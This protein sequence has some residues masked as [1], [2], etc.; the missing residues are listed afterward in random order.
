MNGATRLLLAASVVVPA[1]LFAFLGWQSR[2]D[3]EAQAYNHVRQTTAI[4]HEHALRVFDI[5]ATAIERVIDYR[6][7]HATGAA[8][9][10]AAFHRH[11][12]RIKANQHTILSLWVFAADGSVVASS[13]PRP[14][15]R[16]PFVFDRDYFQHHLQTADRALFFSRPLVGRADRQAQFALTRRLEDAAG[17]FAGVASSGIFSSYFVENWKGIAPELGSSTSLV[18]HDGVVLARN[19]PIAVDTQPLPADSELMLGIRERT[20]GILQARS[21]VDAQERIVGFLKLGGYPAFITYSV[22]LPAVL[23][24]WRRTLLLYA[25]LCGAAAAALAAMTLLVHRRMESEGVALERTRTESEARKIAQEELGRANADLQRLL[26]QLRATDATRTRFFANVSHELRTPLTLILGPVERLLQ[27]PDLDASVREQLDVITRSARVLQ[28]H[29]SDLLDIAK[30]EAGQM[31]AHYVRTDL[32]ALAREVA[33]EFQNAAED[34]RIRLEVNTPA[35]LHAQLDREK[36][37]RMLVNLL[38]NALKFTPDGG[39]IRLGLRERDGRAVIDVEDDGPGIPEALREAIFE[40]FRQG[41]DGMARQH[42]GTGLGLSIVREFA[43][44]HAGA[45]C[46]GVSSLGGAQFTVDLPTAAPADARVSDEGAPEHRGVLP[47]ARDELAR[48]GPRDRAVPVPTDVAAPHILIVED[49]RDLNAFLAAALGSRYWISRAFDGAEGIRRALLADQPD[50]IITDLMMPAKSGQTMLEE[51]RRHP[52]LNDVPVVVLTAVA[53]DARRVE[54]LRQGVQDYLHKPFS[55]EEL[56]ARVENLLK[57]RERIGGRLRHSEER[58]RTLFN[59]IDEGFCIIEML[60]DENGKAVD[61]LFLETNPSFERQTGMADVQGKR[62][63]ELAPDMEDH[64]FEMYGSVALT[65]EPVRFQSEAEQLGRWFD[66]YAFRYGDRENRQVAVLFADV[67]E[68]RATEEALRDADR[69]KDQFLALLA[70]ELRNPLAPISNGVRV[71]RMAD[72]GLEDAA[73]KLLPMMERQLAHVSRLL[74]DLL[75]VSRITRGTIDLRKERIELAAAVHT[76]VEA[77]S[78]LIASMGHRLEVSLP[79]RPVRI[80]ADPVR[81]VQIV[82]NLLNNAANHSSPGSRI[83]LKVASEGEWI[84]LSVKDNGIGIAQRDLAGIFAL[85]V[86][87]GDRYS[88]HQGGLGIGLSIVRAMAA[89]HGGTVEAYSEGLGRGSEFVVRLPADA[90]AQGAPA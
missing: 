19:P 71:L 43:T 80:E 27:R 79:D 25:A 85:F 14:L 87:V 8:E 13:D 48:A 41:D 55:L 52:L 81:L 84:V 70:H 47:I 21:P 42:G 45:V 65:G 51:L 29:V 35:A 32:A 49:D 90:A 63:R 64:W 6:S 66:G 12:A 50:L 4:L 9:S 56:L 44:L 5:N 58:Y 76:A 36:V 26:E 73:Q 86:Q 75:D 33:S 39:R 16:G 88:R 3:A 1:A 31:Q 15:P 67:T 82:S 59:S 77:N 24:P 62:V 53:D 61:Y 34:R 83:E 57:Q 2:S 89:L 22:S 7:E 37:E 23:A 40:R 20:A 18:R 30:L 72:A 28:H 54:M 46:A 60:F 74:D 78:P 69:R 10:A 11:L 68:R 17:R 38:A